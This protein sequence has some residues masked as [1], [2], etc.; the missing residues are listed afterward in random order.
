LK[1]YPWA[2]RARARDARPGENDVAAA[3]RSLAALIDAGLTPR[4]ALI[5]WTQDV[6]EVLKCITKAVGRRAGLGA[7]SVVAL[8]PLTEAMTR[9]DLSL[10]E[11]SFELNA[12]HGG[13]LAD[14]IRSVA[15]RIERRAGAGQEGR[16]AASGASLSS[17]LVAALPVAFVP[18]APAARAPL[19]DRLG[20]LVLASGIG[21]A[22]AGMSWI[23]RLV[24]CPAMQEDAVSLVAETAAAFLKGGASVGAALTAAASA[25]PEELAGELERCHRLTRLGR[26]WP[27][28]LGTADHEGLRAMSDV[29]RRSVALGL[30]ARAQL[31]SFAMER[32]ERA[33]RALD[34]DLRRAPIL[35]VVP[36]AVCVLPS[37]VLLAIVPFLRGLSLHG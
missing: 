35:M 22:L 37:F 19:F 30:A 13:D 6:P 11:V 14:L 36:L 27:S 20:L 28:A 4:S 7:P 9:D 33:R 24:P 16:V 21:L 2:T 18:L 10:M 29:L 32:R 15:E 12:R 31:E 34:R 8:R 25:A 1:L 5:A 17:R 23:R 3:V 26:T